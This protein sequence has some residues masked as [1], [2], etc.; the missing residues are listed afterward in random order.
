MVEIFL[1]MGMSI[2]I[3]VTFLVIA[4]TVSILRKKTVPTIQVPLNDLE[5]SEEVHVSKERSDSMAIHKEEDPNVVH[6]Y[7]PATGCSLGVVKAMDREEVY[8]IAAEAKVAQKTWAT[9][10]F[11]QRRQVLLILQKYILQ[12]QKE[13]CRVDSRDS[14]KPLVDALLGE[15]ITTWFDHH[16]LDLFLFEM[17]G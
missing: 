13:I 4:F 17:K 11:E 8:R 10:S 3:A 9:T 5:A 12:H 1:S 7:D 14:G 6:C 2:G 16:Q 15:I